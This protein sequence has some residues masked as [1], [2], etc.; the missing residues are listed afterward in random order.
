MTQSTDTN[1]LTQT[2]SLPQLKVIESIDRRGVMDPERWKR[3]EQIYHAVLCEPPERRAAELAAACSSDPVLLDHVQSLLA[4]REEAGYFLSPSMRSDVLAQGLD[5]A[6]P[7][8]GEV[9]GSYLILKEA[10]AGAGGQVYQAVDTRLEREVALKV[11][12]AHFAQDTESVVRFR[13]EAKAASALNH[14]NIVTI[15]EIGQAGNTLF[16]ATEWIEGATLRERMAEGPVAL[17]TTLDVAVQCATALKV[18]HHAGIIH[19]DIKPENIMIRSDGLVKLVDFGLARVNGGDNDSPGV[20]RSGSV[21]GTPRYMSP[22]QAKGVK[23]DPRTDIFSLGAVL[24]EMVHRGPA[25]PGATMAEVFR[26]LLSPEPVAANPSGSALDRII[27]KALQKDADKRYTTTDEL[28]EDLESVTGNLKAEVAEKHRP[29]RLLAWRSTAILVSMLAVSI[30]GLYAKW[31]GQAVLSE[32]DTI[33]VTDFVNQT[34]DPVFDLTLKQGLAVQLEQ[35]PHLDVFP[36]DRVRARLRQ[37]RRSPDEPVTREIGREICQREGLKALVTGVIAPLGRYYA[38]TL[39]A[40]D[41][42][43]GNIL[44]LAQ[45]EASGKEQ[46]LRALSRAASALRGKLGESVRSLQK[47]D[48]M[49]DATTP[50]LEALR[51][52]SLGSR[53]RWKGNVVEAIVLYRRTIELDPEFAAAYLGLAVAYHNTRQPRL[54]AEAGAK[55]YELREHGSERHKLSILSEYHSTVTGDAE[56]RIEILKLQQ[57]LFPR[58]GT[59]QSNLAVAYNSIGKFDDALEQARAAV[60]NVPW[61][62]S[63]WAVLGNTLIRVGRFPEAAD[64]Y[65]QAFARNLDSASFHQGLFRIAFVNSD[66]SSMAKQ[67]EW[68]IA[69]GLE[70]TALDWQGSAAAAFGQRRRAEQFAGRI[71]ESASKAGANESAA[72][73][74]THAALRSA[75]LGSCA[76]VKARVSSAFSVGRDAISLAHGALAL[77]WC[78]EPGLAASLNTELAR[79]NAQNSAVNG[80]WLPAIKAAISMRKGDAQSAVDALKSARYEAAGEFWPQYIRG[81]AFLRL[82]RPD[83]AEVEFRKILDHRGQDPITPLYPLAKL[84]AVRAAILKEDAAQAHRLCDDFLAD[85]KEADS[86]LPALAEAKAAIVKLRP[87]AHSPHGSAIQ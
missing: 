17:K 1:E 28:L 55:A 22:E 37:M 84:G 77:A 59:G 79:D 75:A 71:E 19:R 16:I 44:A 2:T 47:F 40:V 6:L 26:E 4:A 34:G 10:G 80:I 33:L 82:R 54:A 32:N 85:W 45:A 50:S 64:A 73:F 41:A 86:D 39:T 69:K 78:G 60:Q 48:A 18:A 20:T 63:R 24:F 67:V 13:R 58:D 70:E 7:A 23:L 11:L 43:S 12:P 30:A 35:S 36:E 51:A 83:E 53:E 61:Y 56:K 8:P 49:L 74:L 27:T 62:S 15:Y 38:I 42:T 46:V 81:L 52:Y 76:T 68:A 9:L 72:G 29:K 25:F 66:D 57:Q 87:N 5:P 3:I 65:Q 31:R 14:P 21:V